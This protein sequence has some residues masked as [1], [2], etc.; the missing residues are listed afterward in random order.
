[1]PPNTYNFGCANQANLAAAIVDPYD[2]LSPRPADP[3]DVARRMTTIERYR[4][5]ET[6]ATERES[7]ESVTVSESQ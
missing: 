4:E 3:A 5:G 7:D 2:L 1:F 6:T